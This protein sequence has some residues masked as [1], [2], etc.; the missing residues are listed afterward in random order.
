LVREIA[1]KGKTVTEYY[2]RAVVA[3]L[4]GFDLPIV[5]DI[6]PLRP[7]EGEI[8]AAR[9]LL[10]HLLARHARSFDAV[11]GDALYFEAPLM[12]LCREHGKHLL[13]VVKEDNPALLEEVAA[14]T[15]GPPDRERDEEGRTA[16]YWDVEDL[17]TDA[18]QEPFRAVRVE[19]TWT[20]RRR[21][22]GQWVEE[23]CKSHWVWGTT[24]PPRLLPARQIRQVG[25]QR[26]RI[27]NTIFNALSRDWAFDH[28]F[29]HDPAAI[30]N[31]QLILCLAHLFVACFRL[32]NLKDPGLR[33]LSLIAVTTL[34]LMGLATLAA[35]D[36]PW[37]AL[38]KKPR[39]PARAGPA[40]P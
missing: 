26:W 15:K 39:Q 22:A 20:Q 14:L 18:I 3:H 37:R 6:E 19:E 31:L 30:L 8:T 13:A 33:T 9:R 1:V 11:A 21:V 35:R 17:R 10:V 25:H 28:C 40:V 4:I 2:H 34:I 7:G 27:E 38:V 24:I 29:H 32:R 23:P 12:A 36:V 16:R 5:L